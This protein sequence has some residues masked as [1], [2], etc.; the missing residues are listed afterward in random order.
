MRGTVPAPL[1]LIAAGAALP[2]DIGGIDF[3]TL[4]GDVP[5]EVL[6]GA[7]GTFTN[8]KTTFTD[9]EFT[10]RKK[11]SQRVI[12]LLRATKFEVLFQSAGAK[13]TIVEPQDAV[14]AEAAPAKR[15]GQ[16]SVR[17]RS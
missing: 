4:E 9:V 10:A 14:S 11:L 5:I 8:V 13:V 16:A 7:D 17:S 1:V 2:L 3:A 6:I 15:S 12:K